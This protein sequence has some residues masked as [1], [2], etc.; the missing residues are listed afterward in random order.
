ML[1]LFPFFLQRGRG[2]RQSGEALAWDLIEG[3]LVSHLFCL[4]VGLKKKVVRLINHIPFTSGSAFEE[5]IPSPQIYIEL[6]TRT[7]SCLL[8]GVEFTLVDFMYSDDLFYV[9]TAFSKS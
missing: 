1:S 9:I 6:L 7:D 2:Y 3:N 4:E 8:F 5:K